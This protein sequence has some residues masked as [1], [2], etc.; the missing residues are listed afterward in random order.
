MMTHLKQWE[1]YRQFL[2]KFS[3]T[4]QLLTITI[5]YYRIVNYG[6]F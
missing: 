1:N 4:S 3:G 6:A 5:H 2:I